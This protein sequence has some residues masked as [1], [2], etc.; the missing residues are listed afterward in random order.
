MILKYINKVPTVSLIRVFLV[1]EPLLISSNLIALDTAEFV[2][3]MYPR[4]VLF[5]NFSA[6]L[7]DTIRKSKLNRVFWLLLTA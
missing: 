6:R 3:D 5:L 1:Y 7:P 2:A 4:D